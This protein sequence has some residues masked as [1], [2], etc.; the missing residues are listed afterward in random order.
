[1]S[2]VILIFFVVAICFGCAPQVRTPRNTWLPPR[3]PDTA[4]V[5]RLSDEELDGFVRRVV[6]AAKD[7]SF[8]Q[9]LPDGTTMVVPL[10]GYGNTAA[11]VRHQSP[12]GTRVHVTLTQSLRPSG[13][14]GTWVH[15]V[16]DARTGT[17]I[18][19]KT[20]SLIGDTFK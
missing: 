3:F 8:K 4:S 1:M 9:P 20:Q 15:F 11:P 18:D 19:A 13:L 5:S 16:F 14:G 12:D 17:M 10:G 7:G 6:A 2:H